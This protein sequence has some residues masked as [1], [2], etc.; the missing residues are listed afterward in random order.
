MGTPYATAYRGLFQRAQAKPNET[1]LVHG[2]SGGVG[3]AAVQLTRARGLHVLGTA[4]TE[5]GRELARERGAH[6]VFDHRARDY[7]TQIL[8]TTSG[9]GVDVI[10]E[11]LANVNLEKDLTILAPHGRIA[12]IGS[13]GRIE[14]DPREAMS[15][16]ADIRGGGASQH[17]PGREGKHPCRVG[18]WLGK[19][20]AAPGDRQGTT[21]GAGLG[22]ASSSDGAGSVWE[23]CARPELKKFRLGFGRICR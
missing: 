7:L 2:A 18:R 10:V 19:W 1:V 12:V 11:L 23:N 17:N 16:D 13:R 9:R 8:S 15:R 21:P 5:R 20:H 6:H 3:T 14:I 4:G 22:S